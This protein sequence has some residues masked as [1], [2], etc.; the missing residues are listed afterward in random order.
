MRIGTT[1]SS[2]LA[3][4]GL[5][6]V[7]ATTS[8][9]RAE[10][11]PPDEP[12]EPA[13]PLPVPP[14]PAAPAPSAEGE[15]EE[16]PLEGEAKQKYV[17]DLARHKKLLA[18]AKD[19]LTIE[20]GIQELGALG[21]RAARDALRSYAA[22]VK[23]QTYVQKAFD[24]LAAIG[25][26]VSIAFLCGKDGVRSGEF[27]RQTFAAEAL[28][29]AK[30]RR[31]VGPL[32]EAMKS[33]SVKIEV[34][35]AICLALAKIAPDEKAVQERI[36]ACADD[37]RDTI[38][39]N[40]IEAMGYLNTEDAYRRLLETLAGEKNTRVRGAAATGL[41]WTKRSEAEPALRKAVADDKSLTVR[42]AAVRA[43]K[44]I[45]ATAK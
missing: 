7:L 8:F 45:G 32:L 20:Q 30:N 41:G 35:G 13:A 18:T 31:A 17:A 11:A 2:W 29:K 22:T 6:L 10:D 21:T 34:Q 3:S 43:L 36:F 9:A 16:S 25:D 12:A 44:E 39:A 14:A 27:L 24:A 15:L 40:A 38:R 1:R 4:A 28:A 33:P 42:D 37:K 19:Q 5:A 26:R 23:S